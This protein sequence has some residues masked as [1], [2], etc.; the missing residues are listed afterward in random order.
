MIPN[1]ALGR[2]QVLN[3]GDGDT[4]FSFDPCKPDE[5][6]RAKNV[7]G[8]MLKA[9][10]VL[11]AKLADG[12]L[13][14]VL[15]FS[16]KNCMYVIADPEESGDVKDEETATTEAAAPQATE[17]TQPKRRGRLRTRTV[18]AGKVR[19]IGVARTAGG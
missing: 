3:V 18:D 6:E 17:A 14:R 16:P 12:R 11:F 5:R 2:M 19:T 9:G 7:V 8:D 10:Y 13:R 15:K 4:E 1:D